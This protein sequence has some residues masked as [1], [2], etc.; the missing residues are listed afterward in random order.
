MNGPTNEIEQ[1]VDWT[2]AA[3]PRSMGHGER[4]APSLKARAVQQTPTSRRDVMETLLGNHTLAAVDA[5]GG[6]PY[7]AT[8]R[9]MRR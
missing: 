7:N 2:A 4:V 1:Q 9:H 5:S 3:M 6:D 8:G